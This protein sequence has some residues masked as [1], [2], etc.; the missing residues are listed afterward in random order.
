VKDLSGG[1]EERAGIQL[2]ASMWLR[3]V[4]GCEGPVWRNRRAGWY[5]VGSEH[6][7]EENRW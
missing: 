2:A 7:V 6:V 4:V 3:C 1:T 5:P